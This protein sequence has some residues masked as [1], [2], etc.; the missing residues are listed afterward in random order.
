MADSTTVPVVSVI[1]LKGGVGK[2]SV[3]L[4]LAGAARAEGLRTVVLDLDPQGNATT[5]LDPEDIGLT[6]NDVLADGYQGKLADTLVASGWGGQLRLLPSE[7]ALE[8]RNHPSDSGDEHR[9]R[10]AMSRLRDVDL[11]VIDCPPSLAQLT[12]NAL[13]ASD[14]V[15]VVTEP[16]M[17]AVT[18]VQQALAA[19]DVVRQGFN[20]RLR[21]AGIVVNRYRP[22]SVEHQYRQKELTS[23]YRDLVLAPVLP[24][25]SAVMQAQGSCVPVQRWPSPGAREASRIFAGYLHHILAAGRGGAG[26]SLAKGTRL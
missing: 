20:L 3:A 23:T 4:G 24:E 13:A 26:K 17:F 1:S 19:V 5:A 14:L 22:R 21:P 7:P 2:T 16:T 11:V 6:A 10:L 18:G 15:L 9:L 8:R 25:R 12:T